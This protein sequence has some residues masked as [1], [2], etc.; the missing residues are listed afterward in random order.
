M[1][2]CPKCNY[3]RKP[4]SKECPHCGIVYEKYED[5]L[6]KKRTEQESK[7]Q[8]GDKK[9]Y[10]EK[11][12]SKKYFLTSPKRRLFAILIPIIVVTSIVGYVILSKKIPEIKAK[13]VVDAHLESIMTGKGNPYETVDILKIKEIFI[14]VLD[15]KYLNTLK[16]ERVRN[17]PLVLD[18]NFYELVKGSHKSYDEFL[19]FEKKVYGDRAQKTEF[20]LVVESNDYHYEFAFLYDVT[21][22]NKLG[23][24]LY[25]KYV[26]EVEPS[27]TSDSG[28]VITGFYER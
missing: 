17:D 13:R 5:Y 20:G 8:I 4:N 26:F 28:Y 3:E 21:I 27:I 9:V 19:D 7:H 23:L 2:K 14:N 22:T 10:N 18:R 12:K 6:D 25:K 1:T 15:F 24:K 11:D 16:R